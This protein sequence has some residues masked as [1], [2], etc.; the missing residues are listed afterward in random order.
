MYRAVAWYATRHG[1]LDAD[2][3]TKTEMLSQIN[4]SFQ[5]NPETHHNDIL[6]N[7]ENIEK[8]IRLTS[9]SSQMKPIVVSPSVRSWLGNEQKR[10]G[11]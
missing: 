4:L 8:E 1:L 6:L 3:H 5:Y 7:R 2:E 10:I 11:Q 9:L